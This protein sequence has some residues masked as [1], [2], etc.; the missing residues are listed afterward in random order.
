MEQPINITLELKFGECNGY[1]QVEIYDNFRLLKKIHN[2]NSALQKISFDIV[3]PNKLRFVLT[4]KDMNHDTKL[5]SNG[6]IINDKFVELTSLSVG[7]M[8]CNERILKNICQ[9]LTYDDQF[10][11]N[12]F[13]IFFVSL[14]L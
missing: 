5:D 8:L 14:S 11:E 1:M 7:K 12:T 4:N 13:C 3:L 9:F 6:N 2:P 10:F